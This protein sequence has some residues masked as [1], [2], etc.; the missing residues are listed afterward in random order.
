VFGFI[1]NERL[2]GRVLASK[3]FP[4]LTKV[5]W[6]ISARKIGAFGS[7]GWKAMME[8][9]PLVSEGLAWKIG[10]GKE[11]RVGEDMWAGSGPT[12]LLSR[13]L[14]EARI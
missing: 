7:I 4:S 12:Y 14:I 1:H 3:Y 5:E 2:W 13:G 6:L 10:N 8:A 11:V 9:L